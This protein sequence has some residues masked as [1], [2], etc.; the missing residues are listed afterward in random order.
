MLSHFLL[1]GLYIG[2]FQ[3]VKYSY[4]HVQ[5]YHTFSIAET[6]LPSYI[7]EMYRNYL[8]IY[9]ILLVHVACE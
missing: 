1:I 7:S 5:L 4:F 6:I 3:S 2:S 9:I 8:H